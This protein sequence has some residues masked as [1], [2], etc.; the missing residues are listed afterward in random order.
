MESTHADLAAVEKTMT[1]D[2]APE[3]VWRALTD[4]EEL[5]VW[6][7]DRVEDLDGTPD[8][9]FVWDAHGRFAMRVVEAHPPRR[10]VWTW[11]RKPETALDAG[12]TT[13]VEW[14]LEPTSSGGTRLRLRESGF[15]TPE[16]RADNDSGWDHELGELAEH[17]ES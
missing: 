10:L 7:P 15:A 6:F 1:F 5:G 14:T 17:L 13:T 9:W 11:A 12:P 3:R 16:A 2:A 4:P 8:G